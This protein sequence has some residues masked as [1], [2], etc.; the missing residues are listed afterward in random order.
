[1]QLVEILK[2]YEESHGVKYFVDCE[3]D[4]EGKETGQVKRLFFTF[5]H[6]IE[7]WKKNPEILLFDNTYKVRLQRV[8]SIFLLHSLCILQL[9]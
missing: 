7:M 6:C 2:Q 3:R 4:A 8:P 5:R 9:T 1:V